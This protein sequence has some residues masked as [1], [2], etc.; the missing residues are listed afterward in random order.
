MSGI[1]Y[2]TDWAFCNFYSSPT[3]PI[4]LCLCRMFALLAF[5]FAALFLRS[6]KKAFADFWVYT[7]HNNFRDIH[8]AMWRPNI[9]IRLPLLLMRPD[10]KSRAG[11][12]SANFAFVLGS[13]SSAQVSDEN[14]RA[15]LL[16]H[17]R[18]RDDGHFYFQ[19]ASPLSAIVVQKCLLLL[20]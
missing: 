5:M 18:G 13:P 2:E 8:H 11:E 20:S 17:T 1:T 15:A 4:I 14:D 6:E 7:T 9:I 19:S 3:V 10:E 12:R 16:T